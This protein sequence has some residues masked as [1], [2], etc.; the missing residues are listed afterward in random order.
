MDHKKN[1]RFTLNDV[2]TKTNA[3]R[4]S[5]APKSEKIVHYFFVVGIAIV[6]VASLIFMD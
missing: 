6:I 2:L 1:S 4:L 5:E 3:Q